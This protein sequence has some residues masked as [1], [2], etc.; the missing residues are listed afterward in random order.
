MNKTYRLIW[1]N[2]K[3]AWVTVAEN[4]R[5]SGGP[6]PITVRGLLAAAV[7]AVSAGAASAL[8]TGP[9]VISGTAGINT[10]GGTMTINNSANAI[11]NWQ[12][13]S[14]GQGETARFI[15]PSALSAVLN[16]VTGG[17]SSKI[18]GA[19]QSNGKVL[20]INPNGILFGPNA[21]VDVNGLIA[22]TLNITNEDFLAGKMKFNA[23]PLAGKVE[24][25][26]AI[27]TP[28]GGQ[29]YLI[30]ADVE[31][32]G[33][34]TAP[35][36]DVLLAAG[37][38]V[39]LVDKNS[40]EI[41]VVLAAPEGQS[42][43]LGSI[44][45]DAGRV[46][47]YG[48]IVRQKG[49][50]AADSAVRDASGRIFLK[51]TKEVTLE[52]DSVTTATG[53]EGGG[54]QILAQHIG[55]LDNAVVNVSGTN[56]G[57]TVLVGGDYQG[58]N[59]AIKN[60]EATYMAKDAVVKADAT[61]NGNGGKV[62]LWAD[63]T[64]RAYGSIYARGG[65]SGGDGGFVETSGHYLDVNNIKVTTLAQ[66]GR[67]GTWLLDPSDITITSSG[68]G[69]LTGGVYDPAG[70]TGSISWATIEGGLAG[71]NVTVT[72]ASG[73][74]GNGDITADD[75]YSF[76]NAGAGVLTLN[77]DRDIILNRT[78]ID[79]TGNPQGLTL[80]AGRDIEINNAIN[81]AA[82][83]ATAPNGNITITKA[84]QSPST[85]T[86]TGETIT[87]SSTGSISASTTASL[88]ATTGAI[89]YNDTST[90]LSAST[91][92][93]SAVTGIYGSTSGT[94]LRTDNLN[95]A[96]TIVNA[97]NSGAGPIRISDS[98]YG[99]LTIGASGLAQTASGQPIYANS[100]GGMTPA[101]N[102]SG[103]VITNN[104]LVDLSSA[105][106]MTFTAAGDITTSGGAVNLTTTGTDKNISIVSGAAISTGGGAVTL[107]SDNMGLV[108]TISAGVGAVALKPTTAATLM[109]IGTGATDAV[110]TLGLNETELATISTTGALSVGSA[111]STGNLN[112]VGAATFASPTS[113]NTS[114]DIAV[115]GVFSANGSRA[116]FTG[117]T[118]NISENVSAL[119]LEFESNNAVI[120]AGGKTI[121]STTADA[122]NVG[123]RFR[124]SSPAS[125][126]SIGGV[127]EQVDVASLGSVFLSN[128]YEF[129]AHSSGGTVSLISPLNLPAVGLAFQGPTV[130]LANGANV[131]AK[132]VTYQT[133]AL[134][135]N[136]ALTT[137]DGATG[138]INIFPNTQSKAV[139][140]QATDPANGSLWLNSTKLGQFIAPQ[141]TFGSLMNNAPWNTGA[142]SINSDITGTDATFRNLN[143][144]ATGAISQ[145]GGKIVLPAYNAGSCTNC[146]TLKAIGGTG[147][148]TLNDITNAVSTFSATTTTGAIS[149]GNSTSFKVGGG[150][151]VRT[152]GG[153][154]SLSAPV[155]GCSI[156][157][158]APGIDAC[159]G[160]TSGCTSTVSLI[161]NGSLSLP[162]VRAG[163]TVILSA[164]NGNI[165]DADGSANNIVSG[166]NVGSVTLSY[167][168]P[169]GTVDID[170]WGATP[171]VISNVL[172]DNVRWTEFAGPINWITWTYGGS[173]LWSLASNWSGGNIPDSS[174][175]GATIP[176]GRTVTFDASA[177]TV[178]LGG[179]NSLGTFEITGGALN[180]AGD[181]TSAGYIQSGGDISAANF[182]VTNNFARSAGTAAI[183][184]ALA[185]TQATGNLSPGAWTVGGPVSFT[186][187]GAGSDVIIDGAISKT[188]GG[189]ALMNVKAAHAI[190][191]VAPISSSAGKLNVT[192]NAH[193]LS[194]N[195]DGNV[196]VAESISTNGG[197]LII[198]GWNNPSET[199][200]RGYEAAN[201]YGVFLEKSGTLSVNTAGG[202]ISI[203]GQGFASSSLD[204]NG[205]H[206]GL[207][208]LYA[209]GGDIL[210]VGQAG[211][212]PNNS[213]AG[214]DIRNVVDT[215]GNGK[216]TIEGTGGANSLVGKTNR[217]VYIN[218]STGLV[219]TAN[220]TI[221]ITGNGGVNTATPTNPYNTGVHLALGSIQS[222]SGG[223]I[224]VTGTAG[225]TGSKGIVTS[226]ATGAT[227]TSSGIVNLKAD[228]MDLGA[229]N[230]T[231]GGTG[232]IVSLLP[233]TT[234]WTITLGTNSSDANNDLELSSSELNKITAGTL[235]IGNSLSGALSVGAAIAPTGTSTLYLGSGSTVGQEPAGTISIANLAV[236]SLGHV[237]LSTT[238]NSITT[239]AAG[240]GDTSTN[241]NKTFKIQNSGALN[242]GSVAGINGISTQASGG[243]IQVTASAGA[244]TLASPVVTSGNVTINAQAAAIIDTNVTDTTIKASGLN[245]SAS[246][247]IGSSGYPLKTAVSTL[248][249]T[250]SMSGDIVITNNTAA[251]PGALTVTGITGGS[252]GAITLNNY[253]AIT[254]V[255]PVSAD[256]NITL[257]AYSP[258]TIGSGGVTSTSGT[259]LLVAGAT[260]EGVGTDNLT[261]N[262]PVTT[263]GSIQLSA[264]NSIQGTDVP[265]G[266]NVTSTANLNP[267]P[268]LPPP[269]PPPTLADCTT[270]PTLSGC[271]AVL[272]TLATCTAT[273]T[274]AGCSAVLPSLATCTTTPTAAGCS[275]VLPTL[276]AC[277]TNP[278]AAGCTAVLPTLATCTATPTAPG[279]SA[280]LPTLATCTTTPTAAGCSA[281]L[282][283]LDACTANPTAAGCTAVLPKVADC[284]SNPSLPGCATVL[285]VQEQKPVTQAANQIVKDIEQTQTTPVAPAGLQ[286]VSLAPKQ[287]DAPT[288]TATS[289]T[290][291]KS[292]GSGGSDGSASGGT[293]ES[294]KDAE[295]KDKDKQKD[296][297]EQKPAGGDKKDEKTKKNYCN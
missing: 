27:T 285:P 119:E 120:V 79:L 84:L 252:A 211:A 107:K 105:D 38:E 9:N 254:T 65:E 266:G 202:N 46:G 180:I 152:A 288:S 114:G 194:E 238:S 153:N 22:S 151:G 73:A 236:Q 30:A 212:N 117:S 67:R 185:I 26:G 168:A 61:D 15:Q 156:D 206:I 174:S 296:A 70:A 297:Q 229:T 235:K 131:T 110:G 219:R 111:A 223:A 214:V 200:A 289:D 189:D 169:S 112:V 141:L 278:T 158:L 124:S 232:S 191:V 109:Q 92:N 263:S 215:T 16:R 193:Y 8:P 277:T 165:T 39:L 177:G 267:T 126:L 239:L 108:G 63:N 6:T 28:G 160:M 59:P 181:F 87:V 184:G 133:D 233:L 205:V 74:S 283:T 118:I 17:D 175:E 260:G 98:S 37:K 77:A 227:I 89:S 142:I 130:T 11:I 195:G 224:S 221:I 268:Q 258:L 251:Y 71:G 242:V 204:A 210:L 91:V 291:S 240:I 173:G 78:S 247:G 144:Y 216:I 58:K 171:G 41:A 23:G 129:Q 271:S 246:G 137:V 163:S 106:T 259:I 82:I 104:G 172:T 155:G 4:V 293:T 166:N 143:L 94:A 34:I 203:R 290:Q 64:T 207:A 103:P 18:L 53:N 83:S 248:Q 85:L 81:L 99:G 19:L 295:E 244:I 97:S 121:T 294:N 42:L 45:A 220:G 183:T 275:A 284:T 52:K 5:S 115:N 44:V 125:T 250:N 146:G 3:E 139:T 72:T 222:T 245:L 13:F 101:L 95:L 217:G 170:A 20:L 31:N 86:A 66:N 55:L 33:V 7:L 68:V 186:A 164:A 75:G 241:V 209:G 208:E 272:P 197:N 128:R 150:S 88:T 134:N 1:S 280:V 29:V 237:D 90:A 2:I 264:G 261:I 199:P 201:P 198:G 49:R 62:I 179:V 116:S 56:G 256:S 100:S 292:G 93:L 228:K 69:T 225:S 162:Q 274:A 123:I 48:S 57:G 135:L 147:A 253:G 14:I 149:F 25:Q 269:P 282:P 60:A 187:A 196:S 230:G 182:T 47:M 167:E 148:I 157:V 154:V 270:N 132:G 257:R 176:S 161:A 76:A 36:G 234:G 281:V 54:V 32:S 102:I 262:G 12:G 50:I 276:D 21:R 226:G 265:T 136:N 80:L 122:Y 145:S 10:V 188:A 273:P 287:D 279:C 140:V 218:T 231:I 51:A 192:L 249:A 40:P 43:N 159:Y 178:N 286:L 138:W 113:L 255:N 35:N 127:S 190:S 96:A 24:N 243:N 213:S